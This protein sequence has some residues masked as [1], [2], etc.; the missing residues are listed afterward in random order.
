[1]ASSD[2]RWV[3]RGSLKKEQLKFPL[4]R[5]RGRSY[6]LDESRHD[7]QASGGIWWHVDRSVALY[8]VMDKWRS[9]NWL[10]GVAA[11]R[12]CLI[13]GYHVRGTVEHGVY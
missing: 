11:C 3:N 10:R 2:G 13:H 1:M 5:G 8:S 6:M 9:G 12:W 7:G 4:A